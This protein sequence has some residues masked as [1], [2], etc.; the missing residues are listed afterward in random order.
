[1]DGGVGCSDT[2]RQPSCNA[3]MVNESPTMAKVYGPL[4]PPR[5]RVREKEKSK[6][7]IAPSRTRALDPENS[8]SRF[9][10]DT[11]YR[12]GKGALAS[13]S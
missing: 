12:I 6:K 11:C 13:H 2:R 4:V 5:F 1:M 10:P 7:G 8:K 9:D 3:A